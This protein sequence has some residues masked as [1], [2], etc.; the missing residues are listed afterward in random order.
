[1]KLVL[2][3][4][5]LWTLRSLFS[6]KLQFFCL[7]FNFRILPGNNNHPISTFEIHLFEIWEILFPT[8]S[9]RLWQG[10]SGIHPKFFLDWWEHIWMGEDRLTWKRQLRGA[11]GGGH[12][13]HHASR[14]LTPWPGS[15]GSHAVINASL[16]QREEWQCGDPV[17]MI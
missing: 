3:D 4:L 12:P 15:A 5:L 6:E 9:L 11:D 14:I 2:H 17:F 7:I 1:M 10:F 16:V 8:M 13:G